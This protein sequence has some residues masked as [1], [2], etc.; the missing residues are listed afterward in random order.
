[1][2][3]LDFVYDLKEKLEEEKI[4]YIICVIMHGRKDS[5]IDM[6]MNLLS[7]ES[8]DMVCDTFSKICNND[9]SDEG[10]EIDLEDE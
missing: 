4:E 5:K 10:W 8:I 3:S 2:P 7:D 1:M 6:H 9:E